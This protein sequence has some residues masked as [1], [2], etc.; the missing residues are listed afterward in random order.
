MKSPKNTGT[1]AVAMIEKFHVEKVSHSVVVPSSYVTVS[2][3]YPLSITEKRMD[4]TSSGLNGKKVL[5][6]S[7]PQ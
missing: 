2:V 4:D 3:S 6:Y 7:P 1:V 5:E